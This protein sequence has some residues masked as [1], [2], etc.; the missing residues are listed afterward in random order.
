MSTGPANAPTAERHELD[1]PVRDTGNRAPA[2][3]STSLVRTT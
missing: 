3:G 1:P 2:L